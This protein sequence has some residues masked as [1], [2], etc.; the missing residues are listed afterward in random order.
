MK[1]FL[2]FPLLAAFF[3]A[4]CTTQNEKTDKMSPTISKSVFG[5][6]PDGQQADLY[7][8][9]NAEGMTVKITN[10]GGIIT[11]L[12]AQ[13]KSGN[14]EDV[15]LGFDSL[16]SYLDGHP[17]FGAL[18]GR[19]GNRI[20][21]AQFELNG[22]TY[23][24]LKNNGENHLH[25]GKKGFDKVLWKT[26][27]VLTETTAGLKLHYVSPDG[28]EG[29]PGNLDVTV[30]Y[31]LDNDNALR[32]DYSA[33]TDQS[34]IVNLTNHSYFNLTG[35]KR[36]ILDHEITINADSLVA[37]NENLIPKGPLEAVAGTPFDF[38]SA[39][40]IGER[41]NDESNEQI[42]NGGGYDHSWALNASS[43][44]IPLAA[45]AH[46]LQSGRY[47]EVFTTEPGIQF[48]TGNFLDGSLTGKGATYT[49]RYGFCFETQHFP[50][51]PNQSQFPT[52]T[53]NPGETYSTTTIYKFST[54]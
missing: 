31:T 41:I 24:L 40:K 49:K 33:T 54:K 14:W 34:T 26:E 52:V 7:T 9:T 10:Y 30:T 23:S 6:L 17:F 1:K 37:V 43:E 29:F 53:L 3:M 46:D 13:D 28:E 44:D 5:N 20:A 18:V 8:L 32:I 15:V 50:D 11:H 22:K 16:Q 27:E 19:Y 38:L 51:S 25:G 2:I 36:D 35:L 48:Y 39:H 4:A 21:K 42:K 12:T 45:T 47:M